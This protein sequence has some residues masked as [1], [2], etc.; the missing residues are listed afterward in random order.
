MAAPKGNKYAAGN[1]GGRPRVIEL[2]ELPNFGKELE[3]WA[4]KKYQE[5]LKKPKEDKLPFFVRTFAREYNLSQ[6]TL[7]NYCKQ[8]KE[9]FGSYNKARQIIG[10][11]LMIGGLKGWW[12]PTAFI[13]IAKNETE[14]KDKTET[15]IT[16]G[17]EQIKTINYIIPNE[18]KRK[19]TDD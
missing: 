18:S 14:M 4:E 13:F 15:D 11:A 17:G 6:D 2:E 1:K 8:S 3:N 19:D 16:S 10:E 12:H 5:I 7:N 9:F